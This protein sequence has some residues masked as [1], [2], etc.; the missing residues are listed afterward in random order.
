MYE[1]GGLVM[2]KEKKKKESTLSKASTLIHRHYDT[3]KLELANVVQVSIPGNSLSTLFAGY[4]SDEIKVFKYKINNSLE[5]IT[6]IKVSTWESL[7]V[8]HLLTASIFVFSSGETSKTINIMGGSGKE[9]LNY[10][11]NNSSLN[12]EVVPR[13]W[14]KKILGFRSGKKWKMITASLLYLF[15]FGSIVGAFS[16]DDRSSTTTSTVPEQTNEIKSPSNESDKSA[17]ENVSTNDKKE[18]LNFYGDMNLSVNEK[19]IIISINSNVPDGGLFEITLLTGYFDVLS[20]VVP[21]ENGEIVHEFIIPDDWEIGNYSA[22]ALFRFNLDDHPQPDN[23]KEIYGENGEKLL[24]KSTTEN[25]LGGKNASIESQIIAYPSEQAVR[26]KQN[27]LFKE[28]ITELIDVSEG[29]IIS[30]ESRYDNWS[31]TNVVVSDSW[32]YS[33]DH[34][35]ERFAEQVGATVKQLVINS[36]KNDSTSVYFVDSYG[37]DIATPKIFGGYKLKD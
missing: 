34:E 33:P 13:P 6:D 24:G 9:L 10:F 17:E 32:Y 3:N 18:I 1:K 36:G 20:E 19:K 27:K 15:L 37:K 7:K 31:L 21:I 23:I 29:F 25:N 16:D 4:N 2:S 12:V 8:D 22:M 28:A 26:D 14:Y 30:I 11:S 5:S 35:K